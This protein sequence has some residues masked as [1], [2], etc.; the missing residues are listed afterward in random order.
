MIMYRYRYINFVAFSENLRHH[1]FVLRL[2]DLYWNLFQKDKLLANPGSVGST[3]C[4]SEGFSMLIKGILELQTESKG[5]SDIVQKKI[6]G[7]RKRY[8]YQYLLSFNLPYKGQYNYL[9]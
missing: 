4:V 6:V 1:N 7:W 8:L 2:S 3:I 9:K 5:H